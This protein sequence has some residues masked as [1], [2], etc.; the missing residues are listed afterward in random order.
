MSLRNMLFNYPKKKLQVYFL[1]FFY[2]VDGDS[3]QVPIVEPAL[4]TALHL[5][6]A[7]YLTE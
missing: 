5:T 6:T 1:L 2:S 3:Y 4:L 7:Q